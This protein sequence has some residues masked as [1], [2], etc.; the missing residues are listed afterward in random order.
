MSNETTTSNYKWVGKRTPRPDG[1]D[2]VTGRA[3]Y[4]D[5]MIVP[6]MLHAKI[7]RSPHAHANILS[8]DTSKA[9]AMKGVKAVITSADIPDHPLMQPPYPPIVNDL[10]DISRN[11]MAREKVLYDGHAVAAVA[12]TSESI[13]REAVK[14]IKVEYEILPH[15]LDPLAA[16]QPDAPVLHDDQFTAN[17]EPKRC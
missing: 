13:A 7:L 15:V 8:I 3:R 17:I 5:D 14:L 10:H 11:I 16:A 4:G 1:V 6:G 12:A 2:K 9:Q